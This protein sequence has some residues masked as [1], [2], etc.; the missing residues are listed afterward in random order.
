MT[1]IA[2]AALSDPGRTHDENQDRWLADPARGLYLVSDGMGE[3]VTPQLVVDTLPGLLD[4]AL[5]A[6]EDLSDPKAAEGV[7]A[8]V[9]LVSRK[10]HE[11]GRKRRDMV[12]ATVVLALI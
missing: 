4:T 1:T 12:G 9:A 6:V 5:T 8:A 10:A 11:E 2:H 7:R 3:G